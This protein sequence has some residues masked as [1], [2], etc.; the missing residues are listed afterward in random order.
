LQDITLRAI[1]TLKSSDVIVCEDTRVTGRLLHH[2]GIKKPL[3]ALNEFNEESQI[4]E[5]ISELLQGLVISLVS[6]SGTPLISDPGF[7][8]VRA[9]RSKNIPVTPLPGPAA[10]I[11]ALSAS[12]LPTDMFLFLGFLSKNN[13]KKKKLLSHI[14]G[15]LS[16]D[17]SPTLILYESP[18]RVLQTLTTIRE[19]FGDKKIVIARELT[20]IYE[21][22][23]FELIS[24]LI[25][26]YSEKQPKGE[27]TLVLSLKQ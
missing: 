6:D 24:T 7:L 19:V 22:F 1:E 8:L 25:S 4:H 9:A 5:I 18:H 11:A 21:E 14:Q 27:L 2:L 26:E 15:T 20:K 10:V 16:K 3:R 13:T 12:G 17:Y 23:K